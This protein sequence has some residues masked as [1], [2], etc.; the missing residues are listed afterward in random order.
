MALITCG[1]CGQAVSEKAAACLACG[2]PI[3]RSSA[4]RTV[5][6]VVAAVGF[7]FAAM[8]VALL[9]AILNAVES[10]AMFALVA[11][12]AGALAGW[13]RVKR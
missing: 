9:V 8:L 13:Y 6:A 11:F 3:K 1:E 2:A 12:A 5:L 10:P 4:G 7:G